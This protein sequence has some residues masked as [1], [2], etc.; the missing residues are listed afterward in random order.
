MTQKW[1]SQSK[2]KKNIDFLVNVN[3]SPLAL[4]CSCFTKLHHKDYKFSLSNSRRVRG[5]YVYFG[6]GHGGGLAMGFV[7][8]L[9]SR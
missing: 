1:Q 8:G 5:G 6:R 2:E 4:P 7:F 3:V 9:T